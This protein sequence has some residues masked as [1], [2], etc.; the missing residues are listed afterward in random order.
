MLAH[1]D[2]AQVL[3]P[4]VAHIS[5]EIISRGEFGLVQQLGVG[6]DSVDV[7]AATRAGVWVARVPGAGSG[8]A[9]SVAEHALL[10]MLALSRRLPQACKNLEDG[11]FFKPSGVALLGKSVCIIGLG[12]IGT[13]LALRL[14]PFAVRTL[15][16]R[17][18]PEHG[19]PPETGIE[20]VYGWQ[21]LP[22]ALGH[23]DYVVLALPDTSGTHNLIDHHALQAMKAGAF[24]I[25]VGRGGVINTDHLLLALKSGQI[26][27]AG[28]DVFWEEPVDPH[29]PLFQQNVIATP[30]I[31]GNTDASLAG[32]TRVMAENIKRYALG[33]APLHTVNS[34]PHPRTIAL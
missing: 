2:R 18:H 8:N 1:L 19:A 9:E 25:N 31:A 33:E 7:E 15:A 26:A 14:R 11:I 16:V 12:D 4:S 24:L 27:G 17:E 10:L 3:I 13:A 21:D 23:S 32:C 20:H 5:S 29:H 30:H 34:P 6:L 28:L 22:Q